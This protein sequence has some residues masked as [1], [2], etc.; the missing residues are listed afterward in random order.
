MARF[1]SIFTKAE[2]LSRGNMAINVDKVSKLVSGEVGILVH[3][4]FHADGPIINIYVGE[5]LRELVGR[6]VKNGHTEKGEDGRDEVS[7]F[8]V[9]YTDPQGK[10]IRRESAPL[11]HEYDE[12]EDYTTVPA[13]IK[14]SF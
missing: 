8:L 1:I 11:S 4:A 13:D 6:A 10:Y 2:H 14:V 3:R 12:E 9:R 7:Y 5:E